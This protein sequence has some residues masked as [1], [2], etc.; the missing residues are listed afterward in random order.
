MDIYTTGFTQTTAERFFERLKVAGIRKLVDVRVSN[1]SQLAGFAKRDDLAYFLREL[2]G[3]AYEHHPE[4][5][6]TK[7]LLRAYRDGGLD[8]EE[9]GRKFI[10]LLE[11]RQ[12]ARSLDPNLFD[13]P[14]VLLCSE[15]T[16]D[17]CHRRLVVEYLDRHWGDVR[18]HHL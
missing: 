15:P 16:A 12:V 9:Y 17:R 11:E 10:A 4:L 13:D 2:V 8:W 3:A 6:P 5:A 7:E 1:S 14:S 18:A